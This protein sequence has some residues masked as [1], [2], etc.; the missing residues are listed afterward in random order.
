MPWAL[1]D[2]DVAVA[3]ASVDGHLVITAAY[4]ITELTWP[5]PPK[6]QATA[7]ADYEQ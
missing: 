5:S 3:L 7:D 4:D 2:D 1:N 6:T